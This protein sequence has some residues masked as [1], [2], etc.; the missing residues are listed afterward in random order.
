MPDILLIEDEPIIARNIAILLGRA[1]H[2][3]THASSAAM[4]RMALLT[5]K[6]PDLVIADISLGD[7]DGL[8]VLTTHLDRLGDCPVIVMSGQDTTANRLRAEEIAVAAFLSKPFAMSRLSELVAALLAQNMP[9]GQRSAGLSVMMYSHD[10][11]GLGHMRRNSAIAEELVARVPGLSVL[12]LVGCPAGMI[13]A[14]RPGIDYI[15]LPSL[16]KL[17]RDRWQSGS[18]R[19]DAETA[20]AMRAGILEQVAET[21][22]P[23]ILLVDHEPSGVWNELVSPLHR[24]RDHHGTRTILGLRDIL[25]DPDR[26]CSRW[27]ETGTDKV[28]ADL[29]DDVLIYGNE[30]FYPSSSA[31]GLNALRPGQVHYC[32]AVTA[33]RSRRSQRREKGPRRVLVSGGGGR[34]AFLLLATALEAQALL[35]RRQRPDLQVI[36]GPLMDTELRERLY[37]R[38]A[39]LEVT[40]LDQVSDMTA[41]IA[42]SDLFI[43]MGGYNSVTEALAIGVPALVVPRVGPSGE[44]RIRAE[45]LRTLGLAQVIERPDLTPK[46][47]SLHLLGSAPTPAIRSAPLSLSFDGAMRA[48]DHIVQCLN[49]R[50]PKDSR[51]SLQVSHG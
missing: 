36:A 38:A 31:Y 23:D 43:T 47:L 46:A 8:E 24:L 20:G 30:D 35:P 9:H 5:G 49:N 14:P 48:A 7:G 1:G 27:S 12:M 22:R 37:L 45:R 3:V 16:A 11:I 28:I 4:A 32:G 44:Q 2:S 15:K 18:L 26:T 51:Q 13:F 50:A 42:A 19:I 25:D 29:Y 6:R 21:F 41:R 33:V 40:F 34:D 10:T 17:G 39:E